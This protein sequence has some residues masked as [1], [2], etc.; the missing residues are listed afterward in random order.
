MGN[1]NGYPSD[2]S[3]DP[4]EMG[5]ERK[6][7]MKP[8]IKFNENKEDVPIRNHVSH[9]AHSGHSPSS[10]SRLQ[11]P[12]R[13]KPEGTV[14]TPALELAPI[15]KLQPQGSEPSAFQADPGDLLR[16]HNGFS[17]RGDASCYFYQALPNYY[18]STLDI[19]ILR[20]AF[21]SY[22]NLPSTILPRV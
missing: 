19:K 5:S 13:S 10:V 8:E 17:A 11:T 4:T 12:S 20:A 6:K 7:E 14:L 22:S 9:E 3:A 1:Q 21:G 2:I 15:V 18:L 16:C